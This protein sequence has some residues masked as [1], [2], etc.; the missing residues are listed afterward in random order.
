[1][2]F[3]L[4]LPSAALALSISFVNP[5][6]G[7]VLTNIA[8][9][10]PNDIFDAAYEKANDVTGVIK[11]DSRGVK[12]GK[13]TVKNFPAPLGYRL[14]GTVNLKSD[15]TIVGGG[16]VGFIKLT[17]FEALGPGKGHKK[18]R[19]VFDNIFSNQLPS[20]IDVAASIRGNVINRAAGKLGISQVTFKA[21]VKDNTGK[22]TSIPNADFDSGNL[23]DAM[24]P[25][26]L[27]KDGE[28]RIFGGNSPWILTG[29]LT[30]DLGFVQGA[31]LY[32]DGLSLPNSAQVAISSG[33]LTFVN[34]TP[35]PS[36]LLLLG[37]GLAG[38]WR[39]RLLHLFKKA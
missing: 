10:G 1:M 17:D 37:T 24:S 21:S 9:N 38:L 30:V 33:P 29:D 22:E 18:L 27:K 34:P 20:P 35:E 8:D 4:S 5:M 28:K 13:E 39:K 11:F 12:V 2:V 26:P 14:L 16:R 23:L 32:A 3:L 15:G 6:D 7:N 19:I 25:Q 36:T 31:F